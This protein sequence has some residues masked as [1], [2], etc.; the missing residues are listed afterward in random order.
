MRP[1]SQHT[2]ELFHRLE[3]IEHTRSR[4]IR[5]RCGRIVER[6]RSLLLEGHFGVAGR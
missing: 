2:Y 5:P 3:G 4:V 6:L 1:G